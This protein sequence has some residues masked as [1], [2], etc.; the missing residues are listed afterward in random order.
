MSHKIIPIDVYLQNEAVFGKA[1]VEWKKLDDTAQHLLV[2]LKDNVISQAEYQAEKVKIKLAK[3]KIKA[4][5]DSYTLAI[6]EYQ[7]KPVPDKDHFVLSKYNKIPIYPC[8]YNEEM[9]FSE[10]KDYTENPNN[11]PEKASTGV[12]W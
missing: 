12:I 5:V 10:I 4:E 11:K 9:G 3:R 2:Q 7:Y 8:S 6:S 1:Q